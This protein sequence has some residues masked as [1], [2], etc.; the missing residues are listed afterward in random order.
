MPSDTPILR[1]ADS[2][3]DSW[4]EIAAYLG[5][6]E[7]TAKR[8]E[9]TRGLP[10]RRLPGGRSGV[11]AFVGEVAEWQR[12]GVFGA[13]P[14]QTTM[15]NDAGL[16]K[17]EGPVI[18]LEAPPERSQNE[19]SRRLLS[20]GF[21]R[22]LFR[23]RGYLGAAL[24]MFALI[25]AG[26]MFLFARR[27]SAHSY[28]YVAGTPSRD[29]PAASYVPSHD[30][31][32]LYLTGRY[33]WNKRTP[34]DLSKAHDL[35]QQAIQRDPSYAAAYVG[36]ADTYFL[37]VEFAAL[38]PKDAYPP[39]KAAAQ[40][41]IELDPLMA[42]AHRSLG[43]SSFYW[44]WDRAESEKEFRKAIE[45]D[46]H[47][48]TAHHWY[49][50]TLMTSHHYQ[51]ALNEIETARDLDPTAISIMADRALILS[52]VGRKEEARESLLQIVKGDPSYLSAHVYLA[53][54]Y[55]LDEDDLAY[56]DELRQIAT[57]THRPADFAIYRAGKQGFTSAG[58][59]GM[60]RSLATVKLELYRQGLIPAF[61]VADAL[62]RAGRK[63]E[64]IQYLKLSYQSRDTQFLTLMGKDVFQDLKDDPEFEQL[65]EKS[66]RPYQE[67]PE[68]AG[69]RD[70]VVTHP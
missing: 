29:V 52:L 11:F 7:R 49:A 31:E 54:S 61:D 17:P 38:P 27:P 65:A 30:A 33:F 48:A 60:R 8:W 36:L 68:V 35:F 3:L 13:V 53:R 70:I 14:A 26:S 5:C 42:A 51:E 56:L 62:A 18:V 43:F 21:L 25:V 2:R 22:A 57:I 20:V 45:I 44:D 12:Q 15:S 23:S 47:D 41:A 66:V 9:K 40:R 24:C 39:A 69:L 67:Q 28:S 34:L 58:D 63:Q 37:M 10:I 32:D 19:I 50:N 46:P 59:D 6:D 4:K 64:A 55:S 16:R 1:G